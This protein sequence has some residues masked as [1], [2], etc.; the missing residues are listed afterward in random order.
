LEAKTKKEN[1]QK[2]GIVAG[3]SSFPILLA[4]EAKE[5]GF[6]IFCICYKGETSTEIEKLTEKS[7]WIK[8]GELGKLIQFFK[9]NQVKQV[10]FAGGVGRPK[11]FGGVKLDVRGAKFLARL[12]TTKDD[13]V[14]RGLAEE[15]SGE[16]IEV[17]PCT[18]FCRQQLAP[19]GILTKRKPSE[20]ELSDID[21]GKKALLSMAEHHIGQ[22]V[23]VKEGVIIAVEAV[24]GSDSAIL[25]G[26]ELGGEGSVVVKIPKKSQDMRFDV[27]TIGL[28]TINSMVKAKCKVLAIEAE[29]TVI[30][31]PEKVIAE[32]DKRKIS[33]VGL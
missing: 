28:Q 31:D 10:V 6:N 11:L 14:L 27:P 2:L 21:Y 24:E 20:F 5:Q 22:L 1:S 13:V 8:I 3:N 29:G 33:L 17:L 23:V 19:K 26:G 7:Q 25:R 12:R 32:C 9:D 15:L 16:G 18:D 30:I 4:K